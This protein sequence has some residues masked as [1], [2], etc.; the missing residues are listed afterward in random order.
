RFPGGAHPHWDGPRFQAP[1]GQPVPL[2][3][4]R[5]LSELGL[6]HRPKPADY[7]HRAPGRGSQRSIACPL[8]IGAA[9]RA[10]RLILLVNQRRAHCYTG[11]S[12]ISV[13]SASTASERARVECENSSNASTQGCHTPL[14]HLLI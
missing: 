12:L 4:P 8:P 1:P 10:I 14:P 2:E 5:F 3:F 11:R 9:I 6:I 7:R 13:G